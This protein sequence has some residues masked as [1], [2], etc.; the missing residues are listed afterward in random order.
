M[1]KSIV[2]K[3]FLLA[4]WFTMVKSTATPNRQFRQQIC[5]NF[6][7]SK[8]K[9]SSKKKFFFFHP[10]PNF[11]F[12]DNSCCYFCRQTFLRRPQKVCGKKVL[13]KQKKST[14]SKKKSTQQKKTNRKKK[15]YLEK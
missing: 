11:S 5:I 13:K 8:Y 1:L 15:I 2:P 4:W 10:K 12:P 7:V 3:F 14:N 9:I 6:L